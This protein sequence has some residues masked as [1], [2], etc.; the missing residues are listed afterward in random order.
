[1][2]DLNERG[3]RLSLVGIRYLP[4][5]YA[6]LSNRPGEALR[7]LKSTVTQGGKDLGGIRCIQKQATVHIPYKVQKVGDHLRHRNQVNQQR[8][9]TGSL[10]K[11][12][13]TT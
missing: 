5:K 8:S 6:T 11:S 4:I 3:F 1:M 10:E 12:G 13:C 7:R 2:T 9:S